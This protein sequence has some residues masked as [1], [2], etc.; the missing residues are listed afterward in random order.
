M[1]GKPQTPKKAS[2]RGLSKAPPVGAGDM[3]Q[4]YDAKASLG[5][6]LINFIKLQMETFI[7]EADI[8]IG[9]PVSGR[10]KDFDLIIEKSTRKNL[11]LINVDQFHD[12]VGIRVV[13]LF[14]RDITKFDEFIKSTFDVI[15][16]EDTG[17]RLSD[18]S[19]GY[20]S[21]HY[22]VHL[23]EG[24]MKIPSLKNL[25]NFKVE[26]QVRTIAQHMWAAVSHK[27]QYKVQDA[28]PS[29]LQ[30]A[31]N[32]SSAILELIDLE[33]DRVMDQRETYEADININLPDS[34]PLNVDVVRKV[35]QLSLP[36][37][38]QV[39][40]DRHDVVATELGRLGVKT[41]G[42]LKKII[43]ENLERS[44]EVDKSLYDDKDLH[45]FTSSKLLSL[46]KFLNGTGLMRQILREE[47][48]MEAVRDIMVD[49]GE[50]DDYDND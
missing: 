29:E 9:F 10:V 4:E 40:S 30:R 20:Q 27:L 44:L 17:R 12:F 46:G 35:M 8:A 1:T 48:G 11:D 28:V 15:E 26:I 50:D 21:N 25:A 42:E 39:R 7:A 19:F 37:E 16:F 49:D 5:E 47:F 33:F 36:K 24:W 3:R 41:V 2:E 31:I 23:P 34:L 6:A 14:K 38:N 18:N 22:V 13:L 45:D 32:R 43:A